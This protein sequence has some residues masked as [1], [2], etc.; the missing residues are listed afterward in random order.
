MEI[1]NEKARQAFTFIELPAVRHGKRASIPGITLIERLVVMSITALLP[2]RE[3]ATG[4]VDDQ[5]ISNFRS[6]LVAM[7]ACSYAQHDH[8]MDEPTTGDIGNCT[9]NYVFGLFWSIAQ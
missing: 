2:P 5:C 9:C 1:P 8:L 4:G 6:N 3:G 7:P